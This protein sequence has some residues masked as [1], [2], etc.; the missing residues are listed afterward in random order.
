MTIDN[1]ISLIMGDVEAKRELI[2]LYRTIGKH[3]PDMILETVEAQERACLI[4]KEVQKLYEK[5]KKED[6][7]EDTI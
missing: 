4:L 1:M 2:A 6:F 5:T 7:G 3:I